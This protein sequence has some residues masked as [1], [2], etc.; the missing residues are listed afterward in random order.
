MGR[1]LNE[2]INVTEAKGF[3]VLTRVKN[4]NNHRL[5]CLAILQIRSDMLEKI[6]YKLDWI[7][8]LPDD[9]REN[10]L[11][12]ENMKDELRQEAQLHI[13]RQREMCMDDNHLK[14]LEEM[15]F[16]R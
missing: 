14:L 9:D 8:T 13:Q 15:L 12:I 16:I 11:V 1:N 6:G 5:Q 10:P 3:E 7:E 4:L 2:N